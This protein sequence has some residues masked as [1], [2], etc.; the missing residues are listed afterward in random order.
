VLHLL[1]ARFWHK[2]LFDRGFVSTAEPFQKLVNQ[3][4]ILG[5]MELTGYQTESGQ[6]L[7]AAQVV[8]DDDGKAVQETTGESV[9]AVRVN[10]THAQKQG[11][12]FVLAEQPD[13]RLE[14][15]AYKMSKSRGNVVNP[16]MVVREYGADALRL[17]EMFM[18][19]LE[20]TKPWSMEGVNGVRGFLDRVWRMILLERSEQIELNPAV[21]D[22]SPSEEQNRVLHK[23]IQGVTQDLDRMAFNTAISKMME[24][25]NYFLK[26]DV[27]PKS[28]MEK[29]VLLL[30]PWAPHI[31]EELWQI[32]GHDKTLAYEP[33][34]QFDAAAV[35]E[36]TVEIPVQ[37]KGKLR[38]RITV[39][40]DATREAIEQAAR[41][42]PRIAEL[43]A[44]TTVVKVII[45]PKARMINFVT[46]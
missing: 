19:P 45:P 6:W 34:P 24:F 33:W 40:A 29:L 22:V 21:Q 10:P 1:Y 30:A 44:G 43:L 41:A 20:A 31:A 5:E 42:E 23:T 7:S 9:S 39:P 12:S 25:T 26:C 36:D 38:G 18:G 8:S 28:A 14:S 4:M 13:V 46:H 2:L 11:E 35:R 17:Y 37:I 27:R 15:R 32:L 3:G 16:D